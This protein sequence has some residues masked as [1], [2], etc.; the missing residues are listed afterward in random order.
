M[1]E[2]LAERATQPRRRIQD[3]LYRFIKVWKGVKAF[4]SVETKLVAEHLPSFLRVSRKPCGCVPSAQPSLLLD[5]KDRVAL[6]WGVIDI[7]G[8]SGQTLTIA[9]PSHTDSAGALSC[10]LGGEAWSPEPGGVERFWSAE[11]QTVRRLSSGHRGRKGPRPTASQCARLAVNDSARTIP[12]QSGG[13]VHSSH[14]GE[15]LPQI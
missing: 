1:R 3:Q 6:V 11:E 15:V 5:E 7:H 2:R 8:L 10:P 14:L 12:D 4:S 9:D 13:K